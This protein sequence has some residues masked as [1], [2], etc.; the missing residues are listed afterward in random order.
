MAEDVAKRGRECS[1]EDAIREGSARGTYLVAREA[2]DDKAAVLVL[3][4]KSLKTLV[5]G[6][7]AAV[8][9]AIEVR[10]DH[11]SKTDRPHTT[12]MQCSR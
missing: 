8:S 6:R 10:P 7:E 5:L 1:G 3:L 9:S 12:S 4:V 11:P 2:E